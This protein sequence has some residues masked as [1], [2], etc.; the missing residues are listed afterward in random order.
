MNPEPTGGTRALEERREFKSVR[1]LPVLIGGACSVFL[2]G[3]VVLLRHD[4]PTPT[5]WALAGLSGLFA[6]GLAESMTARVV[7]DPEHLEIVS[8]FRRTV[9][10]R[11]ELVRAVAEKGVPLALERT[12]GDWV[13]LPGTVRGPHIN[14]VRAWLKRWL[15]TSERRS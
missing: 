9:I 6:V 13:K 11:S 5:V 14:T 2:L 1:W 4:G 12:S 3:A 8:N 10:P 7:L 15:E